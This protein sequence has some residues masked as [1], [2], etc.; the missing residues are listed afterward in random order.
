[1]QFPES[2][3]QGV[4]VDGECSTNASCCYYT[5]Q[6]LRTLCLWLVELGFGSEFPGSQWEAANRISFT[7]SS[8]YKGTHN[9]NPE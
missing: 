8:V 4:H 3:V 7:I 1:M 2:K 5:K 6:M 9:A